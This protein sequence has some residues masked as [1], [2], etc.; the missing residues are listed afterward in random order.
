MRAGEKASVEGCP[1]KV[2]LVAPPLY[3]LTTQVRLVGRRLLMHGHVCTTC[4]FEQVPVAAQYSAAARDS[5]GQYATT[6]CTLA[7]SCG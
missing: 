4:R 2:K 3:V 6:G 1:V 7:C 5:E